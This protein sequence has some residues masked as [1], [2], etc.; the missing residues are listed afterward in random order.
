MIEE[1]GK[2]WH[3]G[4]HYNVYYIL[5]SHIGQSVVSDIHPT[6]IRCFTSRGGKLSI[7]TRDSVLVSSTALGPAANSVNIFKKK[8]K[9]YFS[10]IY[11][12]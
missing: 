7:S 1:P 4:I 12:T 11:F 2:R 10:R 9:T 5:D 6:K 3:H 8:L